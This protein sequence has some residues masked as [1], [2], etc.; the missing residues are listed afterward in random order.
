[1]LKTD[2][3]LIECNFLLM[4]YLDDWRYREEE[5]IW[6][7]E[8]QAETDKKI[9]RGFKIFLG[10]FFSCILF[11]IIDELLGKDYLVSGTEIG[12]D[13]RRWDLEVPIFMFSD[14][15]GRE[16]YE[17]SLSLESGKVVSFFCFSRNQTTYQVGDSDA[18][19]V[20]ET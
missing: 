20:N 8:Q 4:R 10:I 13:F 1:M 11:L 3:F 14:Y 5:R 2:L 15:N 17:D 6:L 7:M 18:F 16:A 19:Q 9:S 12:Y